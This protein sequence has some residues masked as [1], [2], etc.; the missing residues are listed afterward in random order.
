MP[1]GRAAAAIHLYHANGVPKV[2]QTFEEAFNFAVDPKTG[3]STGYGTAYIQ[4]EFPK[5]VR[6]TVP[7]AE[8]LKAAKKD[9]FNADPDQKDFPQTVSREFKT[10]SDFEEF[11]YGRGE[12]GRNDRGVRSGLQSSA[13]KSPNRNTFADVPTDV[14]KGLVGQYNPNAP[15]QNPHQVM[16]NRAPEATAPA[17]NQPR[18][19]TWAAGSKM[20]G[21]PAV[22]S[23]YHNPNN[24]GE[25]LEDSADPEPPVKDPAPPEAL[26]AA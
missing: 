1:L 14:T 22:E 4:Q 7:D 11:D 10:Q 12:D 15:D 8:S 6:H 9:G 20:P 17:P 23:P 25:R 13:S 26:P 16:A 24:F 2:A 21:R 19:P 5:M 18:V 3:L